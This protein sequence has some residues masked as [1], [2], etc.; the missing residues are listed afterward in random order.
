MQ[1]MN[2]IIANNLADGLVVFQTAGG[3]TLDID[4]AE[5]LEAKEA[6]AEALER[7]MQDAARNLVV[8]PTAIEVRREGAHLVP[9]KLRERIRAEGPTTGNS[10]KDHAVRAARGCEA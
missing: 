6:A 10:K 4:Q 7:A 2:V 9:V 5:V 1:A 8:E 3:W